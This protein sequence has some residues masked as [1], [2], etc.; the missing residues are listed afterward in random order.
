MQ[1][2]SS[3][4]LSYTI[5]RLGLWYTLYRL[6]IVTGLI[7]IFQLISEQLNADY[8]QPVLYFYTLIA[9]CVASLIQFLLFKFYRNDLNNKT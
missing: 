7:I 5:Y 9:Y 6:L 3:T 2:Q 1:A 8:N 4:P